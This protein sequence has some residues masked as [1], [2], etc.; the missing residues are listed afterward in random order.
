MITCDQR[1]RSGWPCVAGTRIGVE[2]VA[3]DI[4]AGETPEQYAAD[5]GISVADVHEA[6]AVYAGLRPLFDAMNDRDSIVAYL[7][8]VAAQQQGYADKAG[9]DLVY[10]GRLSMRAFM[11]RALGQRIA[12]GED[13]KA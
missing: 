13:K 6:I 8:Q 12:R 2:L 5:K 11:A 10:R 7:D 4:A 9:A 1:I 3:E